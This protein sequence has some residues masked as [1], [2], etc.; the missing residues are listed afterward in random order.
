M[1]F[2][3]PKY[4]ALGDGATDTESILYH[5]V[6][7][8]F[9][10]FPFGDDEAKANVSDGTIPVSMY[11]RCTGVVIGVSNEFGHGTIYESRT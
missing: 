2:T 8:H 3:F 1:I 10:L 9:R 11:L 4:S 7:W 5:G 6:L